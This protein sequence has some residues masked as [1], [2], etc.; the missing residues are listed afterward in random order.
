MV[1]KQRKIKKRIVRID[2]DAGSDGSTDPEIDDRDRGILLEFYNRIQ[3]INRDKNRFGKARILTLLD[4]MILTS[5]HV[6]VALEETLLDGEDGEQAVDAVADWMDDHYLKNSL[7]TRY[8]CFK[9]WGEVMTPGDDQPDRFEKLTLNNGPADPTPKASNV[10][11]YPTE[12]IKAIQVQNNIRDKAIVATC[13]SAGGRPETELHK[14]IIEEVEVED[15]FV[16]LSIPE[17]TK[18]GSREVHMHP[19]APFLVKWIENHPGHNVDGGLQP[20]MPLWA[21]IR[22][23]Y[24][25]VYDRIS[26]NQFTKPFDTAKEKTDIQK[27]LTGQHC[28][29]S[30]ASDLA[31]KTYISQVDLERRFGWARESDSPRHYIVKFDESSED[32]IAA[33][34]GVDIDPGAQTTN[35]APVR[36]EGCGRWTERHVD[37][38]I[39]CGT[40]IPAD[41]L[42]IQATP[43]IVEEA[44]LLDMIVDGEVTARD[45]QA[46]RKL[47]PVIKQRSDLFERLDAYIRHARQVD[48]S[49]EQPA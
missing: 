32:R 31:A 4:T 39:W 45:L 1:S 26:Y 40:A 30:R 11:R 23:G 9:I 5:K 27:K 10:L 33:A 8:A 24:G 28:R 37:E 12:V 46:L 14:L 16:R 43:A 19:G 47:E 20:E 6:D 22:S 13:W 17:D 38:C 49:V 41:A 25:D 35:I 2:P 21:N 7:D 29:R 42:E 3:T 48:K 44:N 34:D 18:T 15:G 36:C